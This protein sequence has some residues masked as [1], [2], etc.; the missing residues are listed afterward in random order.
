MSQAEDLLNSL[1]SEEI[2]LY[3]RNSDLEGHIVIDIDRH[4]KVPKSLRRIAVQYDNNVETVTFDCPR[5]WDD[6][7]LSTLYI[8]VNYM[9]PNRGRG[10]CLVKNVRVDEEDE[11]M[12]HFEWTIGKE[13]TLVNG[14]IHF[15]VCAVKTDEEGN[16]ELHWNTE[17]NDEMIV[18]E[19]MECED[20]IPMQYPDI[21]NDLLTRMDTIIA[22]DA[23]YLDTSLSQNGLAADAGYTGAALNKKTN[24]HNNIADMKADS[25]LKAGNT[26][27]TLGYYEAN[28]GGRRY[29]FN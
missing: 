20:V 17:I 7:D 29:L 16:D 23:P 18:S 11:N 5:Y 21:I 28:D 3:A 12:I 6:T 4:I 15:L 9:T 14:K 10:R 1:S 8:Y 22:A 19:G 2:E 25:S 13:V 24:Y 27:I 26:T